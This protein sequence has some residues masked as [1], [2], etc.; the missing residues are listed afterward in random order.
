MSP[1]MPAV[2]PPPQALG[3]LLTWADLGERSIVA[4]RGPDA[5]RFIESFTTASVMGLEPG[6]GTET[7]FTDPR[8]W[9][10][11]LAAALRVEDG[12]LIDAESGLGERL[13]DH[14]EHYHIRERVELVDASSD[15]AAVLLAGADAGDWLAGQG[16][17]P[18]A[19]LFSHAE[20]RLAGCDVRIVRVD[21]W[22]ETDWL[23]HCAA[24]DHHRLVA[25][26]RDRLGAPAEAATIEAARIV[27]GT[28]HPADIREKTLAQELGRDARAIS[29]T[30]GCYLGQ[31]TV[32]RLDALGHV[33][34]RLAI[35][36]AP[37][38]LQAGAEIRCGEESCGVLTSA[39]P[40]ATGTGT[41]GM[42]LVP[43][44]IADG[45][46]LVVAGV[47]ARLLRRA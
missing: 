29:F 5:A 17:A 32:A 20:A 27:R 36:T 37:E 39:A 15:H 30:K 25:E 18:P 8:G 4:A 14:L 45:A 31:E 22:T 41:V 21:W 46:A 16:V 3:G 2:A 6:Q 43:T 44:R 26:L 13:R 38:P 1:P 35:L 7:M 19:R 28:P 34:R 42:G 33:N 12:L 47:E 40:A 23:V 24:T 9:V 10:L 11:A